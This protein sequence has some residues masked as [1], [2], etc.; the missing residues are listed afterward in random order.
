MRKEFLFDSLNGINDKYIVE[1]ENYRSIRKAPSWIACTAVAASLLLL[2]GVV[3][4]LVKNYDHGKKGT[5]TLKDASSVVTQSEPAD[6][7]SQID[8]M[9]LNT[10]A[11]DV[12]GKAASPVEWACQDE[13]TLS[14]ENG[15]CIRLVGTDYWLSDKEGYDFLQENYEGIRNSLIASGVCAENMI[16][17]EHG[18]GHLRTDDNTLAVNWRD[19]LIYNDEVLISIITVSKDSEGTWYGIAFGGTWY[20]KYNAFLTQHRGDKLVYLY[21]GTAEWIVTP[22]NRIYTILDFTEVQNLEEDFDYYSFYKQETNTY[23]PE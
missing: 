12:S 20:E 21:N 8:K 5:N 11:N 6:G 15:A 19:Y 4:M 10:S 1:A 18:Y 7:A 16:I 9:T 13:G 14:T 22:D 3:L 17:C 23:T 2:T